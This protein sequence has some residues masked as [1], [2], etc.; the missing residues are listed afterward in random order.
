MRGRPWKIH[1][2]RERT[3]AIEPIVK[4]SMK[5]LSLTICLCFV[6][7]LPVTAAKPKLS[8]LIK[9]GNTTIL[10]RTVRYSPPFYDFPNSPNGK[11]ALEVGGSSQALL[12]RFKILDPAFKITDEITNHLIKSYN[13][14]D[15][16]GKRMLVKSSDPAQIVAEVGIDNGFIVDVTNESWITISEPGDSKNYII[17]YEVKLSLIDAG[18]KKVIRSGKFKWSSGQGG[19]G[20]PYASRADDNADVFR[21]ELEDAATASVEFFIK[22]TLSEKG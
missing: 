10:V 8:E 14:V 15:P 22:K 12:S 13:L 11:S 7:V 6:G 16:S 18:T 5:I 4:F 17:T 1:D 20:N 3:L 9:A 19:V 21:K 2:C